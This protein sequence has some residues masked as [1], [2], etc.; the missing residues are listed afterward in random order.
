MKYFVVDSFSSKAFSGNPAGVCILD[1][2]LPTSILQSI[3]VENNLAETAFLLKTN[4]EYKL[5]WFT[6][7]YE[8]DLCGHA[9]LATAY[10]MINV[11]DKSLNSIEF[12]T[13]SGKL[14]I[15]RENGLIKMNLP[16]RK[17]SP[18]A[19][20]PRIS[21]AL[22]CDVL[23]S[24]KSRDYLFIVKDE[25]TVKNLAPNFNLLSQINNDE[26][27]SIIVSAVGSSCDFVSR[28]FDPNCRIKE[29]PVTGSSHCSLIPFWSERL[30]KK[31]MTSK[32]LSKRGGTLYCEDL[33]DRV[34]VSGDAYLY[35]IGEIN[36]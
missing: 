9:T 34:T 28:F 8:I 14:F 32:Q 6:P 12:S 22:S 33:E 27:F 20:D 11:I 7:E 35:L 31:V 21:E 3:A 26:K 4:G 16:S 24:Y 30:N 10:V 17:P 25:E 19:L 13:I 36:V 15:T 1:K 2:E 5:R 23:E 18:I 29:D